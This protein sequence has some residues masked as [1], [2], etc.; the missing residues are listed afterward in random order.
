MFALNLD[1]GKAPGKIRAE[2]KSKN[3]WSFKKEKDISK[4]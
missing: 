3:E 1:P 2:L 4:K